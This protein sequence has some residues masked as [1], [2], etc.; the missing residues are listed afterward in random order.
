M[1][2]IYLDNNA[3]TPLDPRA[4]TAMLPYL[5]QD[6]GNPSSQGHAFG[7][8][9][10]MG[11]DKARA[12]VGKFFD[13]SPKHVLW[14]SG[15]TES[16]NLAILGALDFFLETEKRPH[17]ITNAI[18]HKAVLQVFELAERRGAE[19][20]I[21]PVNQDGTVSV[22]QI[23]QACRPNTRLISMMAAN[24]EIGSINPIAQ[25]AELCADRKIVFH[26]DAAQAAGRMALS[27]ENLKI[28]LLSISAH[29]M[30]GPKGVGALIYRP[31]NRP[32]N[33]RAIMVGGE[34]EHGLRPG[35]LN[36]PGIV[37]LGTAC[38][39]FHQ[40]M[41]TDRDRLCNW[42]KRVF[43]KVGAMPGVV[44]NG[45][46][47]NRLCTNISLSF[48]NIEPDQFITQLPGVAF[49]SS[50]A[51]T[52]AS[53]KPS[54]VL[55]AIGLPP[56]LIRSTIRFGLGRFNTDSEIDFMITRLEELLK[57]KDT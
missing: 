40:E 14:T 41:N 15:A 4:K 34:Q 39:I 11:V 43:T 36:V 28:D 54:H 33:L 38:S 27:F 46:Q 13:V 9:A 20:T 16:N 56:R 6:F 8:K 3:T 10:Q 29:K 17:F 5:E 45:P 21:L 18:E 35:T 53:A 12:Q 19:I 51:C 48:Q 2:S 24:N 30:Y 25:I 57:G 37:G 50:S 52:S 42:Q 31:I 26:C 23:D 7:W 44:I 22:S 32:L 47:I 55:S 49:S 1:T